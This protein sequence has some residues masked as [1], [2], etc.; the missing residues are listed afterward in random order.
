MP[1]NQN[2]S[3]NQNQDKSKQGLSTDQRRRHDEQKFGEQ[4]SSHGKSSG[5]TDRNAT[6]SRPGNQQDRSTM[7]DQE[8]LDRAREDERDDDNTIEGRSIPGRRGDQSTRGN[9]NEK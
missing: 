6:G 2:S 4:G 1:K 3:P 8:D 9:K 7:K 5:A